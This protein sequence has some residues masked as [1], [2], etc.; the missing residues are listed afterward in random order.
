MPHRVISGTYVKRSKIGHFSHPCLSRNYWVFRR[1]V[2]NWRFFAPPFETSFGL[3]RKTANFAYH[4]IIGF[5]RSRSKLSVFWHFSFRKIIGFFGN[6][7]KLG[8]FWN[9]LASYSSGVQEDRRGS[10][11]LVVVGGGPLRGHT[12]STTTPPTGPPGLKFEKKRC[13]AQPNFAHWTHAPQVASSSNPVQVS[14]LTARRPHA[15]HP[16]AWPSVTTPQLGPAQRCSGGRSCA[17]PHF[18]PA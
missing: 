3:S 15:L 1:S 10:V 4:E 17:P 5:F 16:C 2:Q 18:E 12:P 9:P 13:R 11:G 8:V 6:C 7:S 14:H